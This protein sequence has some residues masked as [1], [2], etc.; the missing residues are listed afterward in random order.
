[1]TQTPKVKTVPEHWLIT[2]ARA[3]DGDT[4]Q[5]RII[6]GFSCSLIRRIRLKGFY[7]PEHLGRT[8]GM[9]LEA[10][11]RLQATLNTGELTIATYGSKDDLHGRLVA[12]VYRDGVALNPFDVL[13]PFQLDPSAHAAD[14]KF[15]K[16][17]PT[18][19]GGVL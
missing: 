6:L 17:F 15:S 16:Q 7:A 10:Q 8:P 4:I 12:I 9:A 13:G 3:I 2:D 19:K 14:V 5:A 18:R 1:M 11:N